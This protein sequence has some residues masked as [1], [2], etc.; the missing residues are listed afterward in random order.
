[1]QMPWLERLWYCGNGLKPAQVEALKENMP[2]C[3]M[4]LAPHGESTG[5]TWRTHPH[6]Y[7][8]RDVFEMYYMPGGTN[9]VAAD[10]SQIVN[11]G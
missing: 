4:Y 11:E 3:E 8:R 1:M 7:E 10:G 5:S 2:E 9:G 6:Y